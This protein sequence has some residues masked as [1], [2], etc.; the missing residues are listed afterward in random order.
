[1]D[2]K[3]S[4]FLGVLNLQ[5]PAKVNMAVRGGNSGVLKLSGEN[6]AD[7]PGQCFRNITLRAYG[8]SEPLDLRAHL[9]FSVGFAWEGLFERILRVTPGITDVQVQVPVKED[10]PIPWTGTAD[11]VAVMNGEKILFDTKSISSLN[12]YVDVF[13]DGKVKISYI[14]QLVRYMHAMDIKQ[15]YLAF[16]NFIYVS[17]AAVTAGQYRKMGSEKAAPNINVIAIDILGDGIYVDG[18]VQDFTLSE[19]LEHTEHAQNNLHNEVVEPLRPV[20]AS[21]FPVCMN[22]HFRPACDRF[23][24]EGRDSKELNVF[25]NY[26]KEI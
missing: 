12:S 19:I 2:I 23:E 18:F 10:G 17:K 11:F 26:A 24:A 13:I 1:M 4:L 7:G 21:S 20:S 14:A 16:A 5:E 3:S 15:G 8:I 9:T 22:C 25:L 6:I